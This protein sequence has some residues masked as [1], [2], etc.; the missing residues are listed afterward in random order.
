MNLDKLLYSSL[1]TVCPGTYVSWPTGK[2]PPLP[3]FAY[4]RERGGEVFADN[5][6]YDLMPR[7]RVELLFSEKDD[8]LIEDFEAALSRVG[9]WKL[10]EAAYMDS[11]A[12]IDHDYRITLLPNRETETQDG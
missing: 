5:T 11:E 2:A 3:W 1:T 10:Y 8:A 7:Y 4:E 12:C 9:T 6:N